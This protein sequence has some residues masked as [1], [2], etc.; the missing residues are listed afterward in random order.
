MKTPKDILLQRH[1][2]MDARLD[3]IRRNVVSAMPQSHRFSWREFLF[4]M[5]WHVAGLSTVWLAVLWLNVDSRSEGATHLARGN[6]PSAQALVA[7]LVENR[8]EIIELTETPLAA[9]PAV[10]PPRRSEIQSV[11]EIV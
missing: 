6:T 1:E 10:L 8:R 5:R 11:T 7:A 4:S 9:A 3:A 2:A